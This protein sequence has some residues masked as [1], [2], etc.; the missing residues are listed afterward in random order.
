MGWFKKTTKVEGGFNSDYVNIIIEKV[1]NGN[2]YQ[3]V[4][5][6]GVYQ[7]KSEGRSLIL[8]DETKDF[9]EE[10]DFTENDLIVSLKESLKFRGKDKATKLKVLNDAISFKADKITNI[11]EGY[12]LK[13]IELDPVDQESSGKKN[14]KKK[15]KIEKV[16]VNK[17]DEERELRILKILRE[18][19]IDFDENGVYEIINFNG[20]REIRFL[21]IEDFLYPVYRSSHNKTMYANMVTKKK[22]Y[23]VKYDLAKEEF[24]NAVKSKI[25]EFFKNALP[26]MTVLLI[27]LLCFF[28]YKNSVRGSQI[29]EKIHDGVV[30]TQKLLDAC[31]TQSTKATLQSS[32]FLTEYTKDNQDMY[33]YAKEQMKLLTIAMNET[34]AKGTRGVNRVVS[35]SVNKIID[36]RLD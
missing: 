4:A 26:V 3:E 2:L 36:E 34:I 15:Y 8:K 27:L 12:W 19:T 28:L 22:V 18:H 9:L 1:I 24:E 35:D 13:K 6:F 23:K 7:T 10:L 5:E 25:S 16:Q 14:P 32:F 21:L 33:K 29:D 20:V 31:N 17:I 30:A 11:K